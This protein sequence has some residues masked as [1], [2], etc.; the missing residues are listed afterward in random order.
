M[1]KFED[2]DH[3]T[4]FWRITNKTKKPHSLGSLILTGTLT[5]VVM[6]FQLCLLLGDK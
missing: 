1:G 3:L 4:E 6:V 2:F 5:L